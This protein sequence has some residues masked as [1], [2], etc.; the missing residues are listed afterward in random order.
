MLS[1]RHIPKLAALLLIASLFLAGCGTT[2]G[3]G[4]TFNQTASSPEDAARPFELVY[5]TAK[6]IQDMNPH[7]Y[8]G[9][10]SAQGMVYESLV[11]NTSE[12]IKPLLAESW[13]ITEDG[14]TYTF[15][16]RKGVQFHDGTP[17][18]ADA[19]KQNMDAVQANAEK[20]SWIK[21]ST[22]IQTIEAVDEHT[23]KIKLSEPYYP[24]LAELSM[25]RPYVFL[26]PNDFKDGETKDGV[27]GFHGTGPYRITE[28]KPDEYAVFEANENYWGNAPQIP[29]I[30]AKVLPAGETT[31]L[32]LQKGEVNFVFT[33]D[34]GA[35]SLDVQAM[36]Q[37][38]QSGTYQIIRS[39]PM[40]TRMIVAN[41]GKSG[42][43]AAETAVRQAIWLSIDREAISSGLTEGTELPANTL[44]SPNVNDADVE[45]KARSFDQAKAAELLDQAGWKADANGTIRTKQG[46]PLTMNLYYD[47][48][49]P[50]QKAMSEFIQHSLKSVGMELKLVGEESSSIASRR[51]SGDYD[52]LFNQ[53]WGLAYDPQSTIAAFTSA[54]A[55][56]HATSGI[57]EAQQLYRKIDDVMVSTEEGKR[58]SLYADI[59]GIVHDE[60]VFIPLTYGRVS[61]VAPSELQGI[62]FKQSQYELPF[63]Q[64]FVR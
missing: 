34:R 12:G 11:E 29:K 55:Y 26:S 16:L 32:A 51:A 63:E 59:L 54:S 47:S 27:N 10:M 45:L 62:A 5:A 3:Q 37:L 24:A 2:S 13:D 23:L 44:F 56:R 28:H 42:S 60:A 25:T 35:D 49:A 38:I 64:M 21:L 39:E 14:L 17:F 18:T 1:I 53:T 43:P 40:N 46:A 57:A 4:E 41:T 52:L 9:S 48:N 7:L 6:D 31:F 19:A 61:I 58:K 50:A 15:H 33:D 36:D 20:H 30:T 22:K 8:T